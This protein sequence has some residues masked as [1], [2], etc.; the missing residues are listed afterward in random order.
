MKALKVHFEFYQAKNNWSYTSLMG[1]DKIKILSYF[2]VTKFIEGERGETINFLWREF[3]RLYQV[4]RQETFTDVEI[5]NYKE[6]VKNWV[7]LFCHPRSITHREI[8]RKED[9]TPYMHVFVSHIPQFMTKLKEKNLTLRLF[10]TS[11]LEK[12]NHEHV[13][14]FILVSKD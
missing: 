14:K 5:Q 2:D 6:D 7:N 11:S 3:Y 13:S 1:P 8:Y 10:S 9:I 4:I 12:K